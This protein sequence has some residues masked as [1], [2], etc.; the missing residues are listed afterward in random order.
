MRDRYLLGMLGPLNRQIPR[1]SPF[2]ELAKLNRRHALE[3]GT[4]EP[5]TPPKRSVL[6]SHFT[7]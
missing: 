7:A 2:E 5:S 1:M 4:A 6:P 3:E